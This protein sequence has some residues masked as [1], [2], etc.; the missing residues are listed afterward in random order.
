[1]FL[2]KSIA[3]TVRGMLIF[4]TQM[5]RIVIKFRGQ[6]SSSLAIQELVDSEELALTFLTHPAPPSL[7]APGLRTWKG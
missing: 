7:L 2:K 3:D 4:S 5:L 6:K 1:M